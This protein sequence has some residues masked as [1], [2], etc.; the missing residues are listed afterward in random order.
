MIKRERKEDKN[1]STS[2][3]K[4]TENS[5]TSIRKT[6]SVSTKIRKIGNSKGILLNNSMIRELGVADDAEVIVIAEKGQIII[7]PAENKRKINTDLST[8]EAQF[9]AAIKNGDKPEHDL[10]EG[11]E[12]NFDKE[13]W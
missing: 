4:K 5:L 8:W 13:K 3:I 11:M 2:P 12:N 7:K 1:N 9:K 6:S 10:F